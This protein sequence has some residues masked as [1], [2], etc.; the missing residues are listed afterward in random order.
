MMK[1]ALLYT[2]QGC[3]WE[4][5]FR[6][7]TG[8]YKP[9]PRNSS[10]K[11]LTRGNFRKIMFSLLGNLSNPQADHPFGNRPPGVLVIR[12]KGGGQIWELKTWIWR[13]T[14]RQ[15]TCVTRDN[16]VNFL[17]FGGIPHVKQCCQDYLSHVGCMRYPIV[18]TW[19]SGW[20]PVH[21]QELQTSVRNYSRKCKLV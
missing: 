19:H 4:Q 3:R 21:A 16:S 7:A 1:E 8:Q 2:F 14:L 12:Y 13:L 15:D 18:S 17:S 6:K 20:H 10:C 5:L 9:W 11:N